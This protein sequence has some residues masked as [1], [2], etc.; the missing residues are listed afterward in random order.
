[1]T[2]K[3][4]GSI[5]AFLQHELM[6]CKSGAEL[7]QLREMRLAHLRDPAQHA[8]R[9]RCVEIV[10]NVL[11]HARETTRRNAKYLAAR[12]VGSSNKGARQFPREIVGHDRCAH[13]EKIHAVVLNAPSRR[14][15]IVAQSRAYSRLLVRNHGSSDGPGADQHATLDAIL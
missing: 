6:R 11:D 10:P 13:D 12:N 3:F 14:V 9:Q 7:E 2:E 5:N 15:G 1:L 4:L 8:Y